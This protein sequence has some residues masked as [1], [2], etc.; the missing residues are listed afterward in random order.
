MSG[1][2]T[3][4]AQ[5]GRPTGLQLRSGDADQVAAPHLAPKAIS[6]AGVRDGHP[7]ALGDGQGPHVDR[8]LGR[9]QDPSRARLADA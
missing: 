4:A 9:L 5:G 3:H 6:P 2:P 7:R 8:Q 1:P